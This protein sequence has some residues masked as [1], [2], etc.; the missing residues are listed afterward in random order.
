MEEL[1]TSRPLRKV[2]QKQTTDGS[3]T[4]TTYMRKWGNLFVARPAK[5]FDGIQKDASI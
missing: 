1:N 5:L 2:L 3:N 4:L